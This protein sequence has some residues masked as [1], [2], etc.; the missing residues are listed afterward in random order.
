MEHVV[1]IPRLQQLA[2]FTEALRRGTEADRRT[3][4]QSLADLAPEEVENLLC[5]G[6][7]S[8]ESRP[9]DREKALADANSLGIESL[10][11]D[12]LVHLQ[13]RYPTGRDV[14]V[15]VSHGCG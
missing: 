8:L 12:T 11:R 14:S 3:L 5:N 6:L 15:E 10:V 2:Q 7:R 13:D 9:E 4:W 1:I